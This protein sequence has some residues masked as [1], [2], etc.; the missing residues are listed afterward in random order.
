MRT[1]FIS[2]LKTWKN[3]ITKPGEQTFAAERSKPSATLKTALAW[4]L[5]AGVIAALLDILLTTLTEMWVIPPDEVDS[6]EPSSFTMMIVQPIMNLILRYFFLYREFTKLYGWLWL[7]SGL[8]DLA[9]D[10][11][12][13]IVYYIYYI[14][15]EIPSWQRAIAKG[16]LSPVS[17]LVKVGMYH[18]VVTF[19]GGRGQ[20]GRYAYLLAAIAVPMTFLDSLLDFLPLAVARLVAVLPGSSFMAGQI[21][22]YSLS[23]S[24]TFAASLIVLVY[25]LVLFYFSTKVEHGMTWWRAV[26]GVV[27]SYLVVFVLRTV[28]PYGL[29]G[30]F[31]A[32]RI[33]RR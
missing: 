4:I 28:W 31:E 20:F 7:H 16:L 23:G 15:E 21:W 24:A 9:A 25:W 32:G 12:N 17:F 18:C 14:L 11:V 8:F 29:L 2:M 10:S 1:K 26:I 5:L 19:W 33:L 27:T 3:V 13:R 6:S 22:Y 30:L